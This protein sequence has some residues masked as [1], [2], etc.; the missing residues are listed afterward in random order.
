MF[1]HGKK[2]SSTSKMK[3]FYQLRWRSSSIPSTVEIFESTMKTFLKFLSQRITSKLQVLLNSVATTRKPFNCD[4]QYRYIVKSAPMANWHGLIDGVK[5]KEVSENEEF[6]S[7][8]DAEQYS[9]L[10]CRDDLSAPLETFVFKSVMRTTD[11]K[12]EGR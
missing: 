2:E 7:H 6:M 5:C 8:F 10:L 1:A 9:C 3:A 12:Q 4:V 11:Q